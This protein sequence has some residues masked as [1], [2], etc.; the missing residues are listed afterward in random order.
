MT[1]FIHSIVGVSLHFYVVYNIK[2]ILFSDN[3]AAIFIK[4]NQSRLT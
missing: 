4:S 1:P 3:H 2:L